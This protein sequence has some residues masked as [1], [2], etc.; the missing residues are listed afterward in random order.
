[1]AGNMCRCANYNRYVEAVVA[2]RHACADRSREV[3]NEQQP[4][5]AP[6]ARA[7]GDTPYATPMNVIGHATPRIDAA[8]RVSGRAKYTRDV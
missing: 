4:P 2:R 8:E 3:R 1:M 5:Q 6:L 7:A